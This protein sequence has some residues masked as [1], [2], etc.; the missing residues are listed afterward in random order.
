MVGLTGLRLYFC[1]RGLDSAEEVVVSGCSAG[2]QIVMM[3][4]DRLAKMLP[5][6]TI[7]SGV[8]DSG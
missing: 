5:P 8:P 6:T 7:L 1:D 4:I 3:N 2:G